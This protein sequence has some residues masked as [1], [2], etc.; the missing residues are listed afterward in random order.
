M[1]TCTIRANIE[2]WIIQEKEEKQEEKENKK[3]KGKTKKINFQFGHVYLGSRSDSIS[4]AEL[5]IEN[6]K[7]SA[8]HDLRKKIRSCLTSLRL[9]EGFKNLVQVPASDKVSRLLLI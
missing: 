2:A 6:V 1:A 3:D 7:D 5:A 4:I 8:Y 9:K